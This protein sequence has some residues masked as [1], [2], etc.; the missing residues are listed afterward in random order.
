M[1]DLM[2]DGNAVAG[3]LMEVFG[4]E[5]TTARGR[6]A[7]CGA[8]EPIGALRAYRG[9]GVVLRCPHCDHALVRITE[10]ATGVWI[11]LDGVRGLRMELRRK[12]PGPG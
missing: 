12:S 7:D 11:S 4:T 8:E 1:D 3:L 5:M 10:N 9:A 2:L 6:C